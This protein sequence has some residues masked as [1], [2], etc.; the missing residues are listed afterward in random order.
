MGLL[1]HTGVWSS[2]TD[3]CAPTKSPKARCVPGMLTG[4]QLSRCF[5]ARLLRASGPL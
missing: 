1:L 4:L 5:L 2:E 3:V